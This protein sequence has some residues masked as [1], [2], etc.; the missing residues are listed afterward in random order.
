VKES[1]REASVDW[2]MVFYGNAVHSFSNPANWTDNSMGIAYN[3]VA[4]T[5]SWY[6]M[7]LFLQEIFGF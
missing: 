7:Q 1:L 6:L 2:Q 4:G 5:R 3:A